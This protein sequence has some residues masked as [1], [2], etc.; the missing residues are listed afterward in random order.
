MY[1]MEEFIYYTYMSFANTLIAS[2][3]LNN[4]LLNLFHWYSSVPS[5]I[6]LSFVGR[7]YTWNEMIICLSCHGSDWAIHYIALCKMLLFAK[8]QCKCSI[9]LQFVQWMDKLFYLTHTCYFL[10][11]WVNRS[12]SIKFPDYGDCWT[13]GTAC[14]FLT[15][16]KLFQSAFSVGLLWTNQSFS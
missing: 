5:W 11:S 16:Y 8:L 2:C 13:V 6:H 3:M 10:F 7:L 4:T 1:S 9:D 14:L 12:Y 15:S